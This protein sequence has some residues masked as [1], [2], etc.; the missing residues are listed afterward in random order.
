[1]SIGLTRRQDVGQIRAAVVIQ[2]V[3]VPCSGVV[4][5]W[6]RLLP[7]AITTQLCFWEAYLFPCSNRQ[8]YLDTVKGYWRLPVQVHQL[9]HVFT[10]PTSGSMY[11]DGYTCLCD[12]DGTFGGD[13]AFS[14]GPSASCLWKHSNTFLITS[15]RLPTSLLISQLPLAGLVQ[16]DMSHV[17]LEKR[18]E[19]DCRRLST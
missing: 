4:W 3:V 1:M 13:S 7:L 18:E 2:Q 11:D 15:R 14:I 6:G 16:V 9:P 8:W 10:S 17:V 19:Q 5:L 12:G